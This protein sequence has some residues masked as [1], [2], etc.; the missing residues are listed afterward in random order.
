MQTPLV[1]HKTDRVSGVIVNAE[2]TA[3]GK[4]RTASMMAASAAEASKKPRVGAALVGKP[5]KVI[6]LRNMVCED[7]VSQAMTCGGLSGI[8]G[9]R[10]SGGEGRYLVC[11]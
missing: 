8:M 6:C 11:L 3:A 10:R 1:A 4:T 5:S 2:P 9:G 7:C